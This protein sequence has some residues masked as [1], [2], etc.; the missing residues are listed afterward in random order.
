MRVGDDAALH[1]AATQAGLSLADIDEFVAAVEEERDPDGPRT[2]RFLSRVRSGAVALAGGMT[3]EV[4]A[5]L[6][7]EAIGQF[8]GLS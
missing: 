7:V 8:L 2:V 4:A 6:L 1:R 3:S 5:G